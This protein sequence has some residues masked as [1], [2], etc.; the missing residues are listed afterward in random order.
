MS[1]RKDSIKLSCQLTHKLHSDKNFKFLYVDSTM[2]HQHNAGQEKEQKIK[3]ADICT[4]LS[5]TIN[6][7]THHGKVTRPGT[8]RH[9]QTL[10]HLIFHINI[11]LI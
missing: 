1:K 2:M 6:M 9:D 5:L 7:P 11:K 4:T 8:T 10:I 3:S